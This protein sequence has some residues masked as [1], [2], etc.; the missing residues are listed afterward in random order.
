MLGFVPSFV[1][2]DLQVIQTSKVTFKDPFFWAGHLL[3]PQNP[4]TRGFTARPNGFPGIPKGFLATPER[5]D[6][7][8]GVSFITET[9]RK[10]F[11]FQETKVIGFL[12]NVFLHTKLPTSDLQIWHMGT[13]FN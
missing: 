9:K 3:K 4:L 8:Q 11:R 1:I 5:Q 13:D 7:E 10:V 6:D 2:H 12:T